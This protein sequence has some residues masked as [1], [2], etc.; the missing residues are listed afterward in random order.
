MSEQQFQAQVMDELRH[1][2]SIAEL[3]GAL[4]KAQGEMCGALKDSANPFFKSKYADLASVVDAIRL[5]FSDH[6]LSYIQVVHDRANGV[7]VETLLMHASGQWIKC[8]KVPAPVTKNDAQ[9]YGSAITYARRYSLMAACGVAPEDDDGNA[10]AKNK[11]DAIPQPAKTAPAKSVAKDVYDSMTDEQQSE[12]TYMARPIIDA[13][14]AGNVDE[15]V[16]K[17]ES[18]GLDADDKTALWSLLASNYRSAITKN[19]QARK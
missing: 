14:D 10:A 9:G 5:P 17:I 16:D 12:I 7:A 3:A 18:Y 6:G 13:M 8:G 1:S 2:E 11:P 4:A 19:I 15:A